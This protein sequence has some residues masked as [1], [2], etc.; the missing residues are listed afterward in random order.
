MIAGDWL[1]DRAAVEKVVKGAP[2]QINHLLK[3]GVDF[4]RKEDG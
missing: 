1:S 3:W 2:E 4:D